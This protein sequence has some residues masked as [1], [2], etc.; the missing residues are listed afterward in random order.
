[1]VRSVRRLP[2][3]AAIL[4]ETFAERLKARNALRTTWHLAPVAHLPAADI[5]AR[6]RDA[7]PPFLLPPLLPPYRDGTFDFAFGHHAPMEVLTA[8]ADLR[9]HR[10]DVCFAAQAPIVAQQAIA[11]ELGLP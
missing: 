8:V 7:H 2:S 5:R 3:G 4:A 10:A 1:G 6:L 9:P 11:A